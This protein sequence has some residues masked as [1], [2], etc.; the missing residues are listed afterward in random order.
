M[1]PKPKEFTQ[2]M[3]KLMNPETAPKG[4]KPWLLPVKK[5]GKDPDTR[6]SWKAEKSRL[7]PAEAKRRLK[8]N[9]GNVG[10]SGR[11][12][13]RLILLDIDDPSIEDQLKPTL[14]I[15]SRSRV[16]THAIYWAHP[17]DDKLPANIPTEKGELRT[18]DQYVV[19]PGSYVPCTESELNEKRAEGEINREQKQR[20]LNDEDRGYYTLDNDK[21]IATIKFEELPQVF[22]QEYE[23]RQQREEEALNKETDFEPEEV[24]A[25]DK[26]ALFELT[27]TDL[28]SRGLDG[29]DPHPLHASSTG[30]NWSIN[31]GVGHCWRHEVSLNALQFLCVESGYL[32]CHEAGTPHKGHGSAVIGNYEAIWEAWLHAKKTGYIPEDDPV[33]TKA[34]KYIAKKHDVCDPSGMDLLPTNAYNKTIEIVEEKY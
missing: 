19:A 21:E 23:N 34:L 13:D 31:D 18:D 20:V 7:T 11:R 3:E 29:R 6:I 14:K 9:Y 33:P 10:L 8:H 27:I 15:R 28:T 26:S 17:E 30:A 24:K 2:F 22:Q 32:N 12:D 1:K 5:K 16:G 4:Y 25:K